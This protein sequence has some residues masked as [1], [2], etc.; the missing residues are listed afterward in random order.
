MK[1]L[2]TGAN[3]DIAISIFE[4]LKREYKGI[5][6]FGSDLKAGYGN[7]YFKKIF[8]L[9]HASSKN[10]LKNSR[11]LF[12]KFDL[13]V[14]TT[15]PEISFIANNKEKY[16]KNLF[17]INNKEIVNLFLDKLKTFEFLKKKKLNHLKFCENLDF[18]KKYKLPFFLKTRFGAGNKNYEIIKEK[19]QLNERY[20]KIFKKRFIVQE[21]LNSKKE[22]TSCIYKNM[23]FVSIIIFERKLNKDFTYYAKPIKS[24]ILHN[25]LKKIASHIPFNG[26]INIQF[27]FE[28]KKMKIFEINPRLSSTVM[29]RN[30][31]GF[32]DCVW[33]INDLIGIKTKKDTKNIK[34]NKILLKKNII[35]KI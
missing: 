11:A 6:I 12:K 28:K 14:P 35:H 32:K 23:D 21:Y 13:I 33:W 26:S 19:D 10:Y 8:L 29:M 3:G 18:K 25:K 16:Q 24:K 7:L 34:Y 27:K 5:K 20:Y 15:E 1:V 22:Y 17:L 31:I 2:I 4:I 30:L 9:P